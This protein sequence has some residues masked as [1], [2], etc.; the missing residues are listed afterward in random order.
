MPKSKR[1]RTVSLTATKK[2][3]L[4]FKQNL[5]TEIRECLDTYENLFII[6]MFNQR[7][8]FLKE[9]RQEWSDSKFLFGKNKVIA[10]ALGRG[11]ES[12]YKEN[13]NKIT[14]FLVG[15][16]GL[17]FSNKTKQEVVEYFE[18]YECPDYARSGNIATED[19]TIYAGPLTQ[20]QHTM[21]P[22]LRKLGMH[23]SLKRGIVTLDSDFV[24]CKKGDKLTPDQARLLKLFESMQATFKIN[25]KVYWN[26]S[27]DYEIIDSTLEESGDNENGDSQGQDSEDEEEEEMAQSDEEDQPNKKKLKK[28]I[29]KS[30]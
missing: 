4:E 26:K 15:N 14:P 20:F 11:P 8:L 1:D 25:V 2:K 9:L 5:I 6:S 7:N 19:L 17:L 10:L 27:G 29:E 13:L 3:G 22:Q 28:K 30:K 18:S 12:E 21:E 16:I 24:V 23:T